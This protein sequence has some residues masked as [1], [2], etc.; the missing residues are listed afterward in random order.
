MN[1]P[2]C[3]TQLDTLVRVLF[4]M[5]QRDEVRL[6]GGDA[7]GGLRVAFTG[8]ME[9]A[10]GPDTQQGLE[11]PHCQHEVAG[12]SA[13]ALEFV[14]IPTPLCERVSLQGESSEA[15]GRNGWFRPAEATVQRS[16]ADHTIRLSV[17]SRRPYG[18]MPPIWLSLSVGDARLLHQ[19]LGRQL[20]VLGRAT[21]QEGH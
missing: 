11:C 13:D 19:A 6:L 15:R 3:H 20:A 16:E 7:E 9:L 4:P 14:D 12:L 10:E 18:D 5:E 2:N 1:C 21:D 17:R 8:E